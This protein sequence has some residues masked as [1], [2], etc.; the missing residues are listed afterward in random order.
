M[1]THLMQDLSLVPLHVAQAWL[2][3]K[4]VHTWAWHPL[5]LLS[6]KASHPLL[7]ADTRRLPFLSTSLHFDFKDFFCEILYAFRDA[8]KQLGKLVSSDHAAGTSTAPCHAQ[9]Y[10]RTG[11]SGKHPA[12]PGGGGGGQESLQSSGEWP[13][14]VSRE[15]TRYVWVFKR[16]S[17]W[18][19]G[20]HIWSRVWDKPKAEESGGYLSKQRKRAEVLGR[21][22]GERPRKG[23]E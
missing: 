15:V 14:D 23:N 21:G 12:Q 11:D 17:W 13:K 5:D 10:K 22:H 2:L 7:P 16:S 8:W 20:G 19:C 4:P 6:T 18:Q 9:S 3:L 1:R